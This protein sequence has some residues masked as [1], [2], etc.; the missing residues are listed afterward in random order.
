MRICSSVCADFHFASC[1]VPLSLSCMIALAVA[2]A[3][4]QFSFLSFLAISFGDQAGSQ[5]HVEKKSPSQLHLPHCNGPA[6]LEPFATGLLEP[7]VRN[8]I[9]GNSC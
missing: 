6:E 9:S 1:F 7:I 8:G 5:W 4:V 2:L 3:T